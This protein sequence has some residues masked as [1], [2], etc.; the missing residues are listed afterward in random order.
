DLERDDARIGRDGAFKSANHL[1]VIGVPK[2][3]LV[4][5]RIA[6]DPP[7]VILDGIEDAALADLPDRDDPKVQCSSALGRDARGVDPERLEI[8]I[9]ARLFVK[10][11]HD[12]IAIIDESPVPARQPFDAETFEA[13]LFTHVFL[14]ATNDGVDLAIAP[15]AHDDHIIGIIDFAAH[16]DDLDV[17]SLLVHRGGCDPEREGARIDARHH[18]RG[19]FRLLLFHYHARS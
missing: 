17:Q 11:V 19:L 2:L 18:G 9:T 3:D 12:H 4:E 16:I 1:R 5:A 15:A 8:V 6:L 10:D 7:V 14:D 13:E